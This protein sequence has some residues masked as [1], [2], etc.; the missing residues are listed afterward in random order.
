MN[1]EVQK[2]VIN[3]CGEPHFSFFIRP[4]KNSTIWGKCPRIWV[5]EW[6]AFFKACPWW[7]VSTHS[8]LQGTSKSSQLCVSSVHAGCCSL[9][10]TSLSCMRTWSAYCACRTF[11][12]GR[13]VVKTFLELEIFTGP[14][15]IYLYK[16]A[17]ITERALIHKC[18]HLLHLLSHASSNY[19]NTWAYACRHCAF[20][21]YNHLEPWNRRCHNWNFLLQSG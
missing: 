17:G 21:D 19:L 4:Q 5:L 18:K 3:R 12:G 7:G 8:R 20:S 9:C 6:D 1:H 11:F 14:N 10:R 2:F 13:K 16:K 15:Q